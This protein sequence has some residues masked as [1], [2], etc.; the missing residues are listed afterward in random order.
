MEKHLWDYLGSRFSTDLWQA[1]QPTAW[2]GGAPEG[3]NGTLKERKRK[4][5]ESERK[6]EK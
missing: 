1:T 6:D 4:R 5:K 3:E 2:S